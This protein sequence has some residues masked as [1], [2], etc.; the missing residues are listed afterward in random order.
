MQIVEKYPDGVFNWVDLA[1]TDPEGAKAFYASLFGWEAIDV[2]T[3]MG[4]M[5][6]MF[7]LDGQ[8]VAGAGPLQPDMQ[9]QGIP[10][11][12]SS[13]VKHD[14]VDAVAAKIIMFLE[15]THWK[16]TFFYM[17]REQEQFGI[18]CIKDLKM[19]TLGVCN[20][21]TQNLRDMSRYSIP[22]IMG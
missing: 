1:T 4:S 20:H 12:W 2:P 13:Y 17:V 18:E 16:Y 11:H 19:I 6:T 3:G 9:A 10:S 21:L 14:D 22:D 15:M 5:Y 7:K 8:N